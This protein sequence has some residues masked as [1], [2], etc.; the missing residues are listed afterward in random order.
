MGFLNIFLYIVDV[1]Y[2]IDYTA[3]EVKKRRY[4]VL[5]LTAPILCTLHPGFG[6]N[7]LQ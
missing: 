6:E 4:R 1:E 7:R 2:L 3:G 5:Y